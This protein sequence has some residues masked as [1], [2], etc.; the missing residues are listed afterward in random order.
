MPTCE[1]CGTT[2]RI[3]PGTGFDYYCPMCLTAGSTRPDSDGTYDPEKAL[4]EM[5]RLHAEGGPKDF[6]QLLELFLGLDTYLRNG[7]APPRAWVRA[8]KAARVYNGDPHQLGPFTPITT[9]R[10]TIHIGP[11]TTVRACIDCGVLISGG[12]TRCLYCASK[13]TDAQQLALRFL[14]EKSG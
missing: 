3:A 9:D 12:P 8:F 14:S 2:L 11:F 4:T 7:G 5:A 1:K 13:L 10:D 6:E